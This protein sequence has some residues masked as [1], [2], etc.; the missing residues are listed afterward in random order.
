MK[1][2][3]AIALSL[4]FL[5]LFSISVSAVSTPPSTTA[6]KVQVSEFEIES[7]IAE[8][9]NNAS[10]SGALLHPA[11]DLLVDITLSEILQGY[12][13]IEES[14]S[15]GYD[16][17]GNILSITALAVEPETSIAEEGAISP[18]YIPC[19]VGPGPCGADVL[20]GV[21][22]VRD[23]NQEI[24]YYVKHYGCKMCKSI[25]YSE[26]VWPS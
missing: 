20:I 10:F 11:D 24:K 7:L 17:S 16:S 6:I 13:V 2:T 9:E 26:V 22:I 8:A 25:S 19:P 12:D 21:D 18:Q 3:C 15:T 14:S 23:E 5:F 4:V 1:K